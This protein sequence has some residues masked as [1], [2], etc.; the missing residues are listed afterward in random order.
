[1]EVYNILNTRSDEYVLEGSIDDCGGF[2]AVLAFVV[3]ICRII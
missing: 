2:C 1:M 3:V